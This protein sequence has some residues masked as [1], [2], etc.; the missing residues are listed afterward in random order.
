MRVSSSALN[1]QGTPQSEETFG[2]DEFKFLS[3]HCNLTKI[4]QVL[5]KDSQ[6]RNPH[7]HAH[8]GP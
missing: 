3:V 4:E 7:A 8:F 2:F 5:T 1:E 6:G